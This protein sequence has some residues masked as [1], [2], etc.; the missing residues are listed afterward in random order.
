MSH[1]QKNDCKQET[2]NYASRYTE[3]AMKSENFAYNANTTVLIV[4]GLAINQIKPIYIC[5]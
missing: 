1:S 5:Q 4:L 3:W 2:M